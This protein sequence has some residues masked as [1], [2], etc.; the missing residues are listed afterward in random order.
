MIT[1]ELTDKII[2]SIKYNEIYYVDQND[3]LDDLS[4]TRWLELIRTGY[5]EIGITEDWDTSYAEDEIFNW[6]IKDFFPDGIEDEDYS[7]LRDIIW[8]NCSNDPMSQLLRHTKDQ[9]IIHVIGD[10]DDVELPPEVLDSEDYGEWDLYTFRTGILLGRTLDEML[11][12]FYDNG[13]VSSSEYYKY[14]SIYNEGFGYTQLC[15]AYKMKASDIPDIR[16]QFSNGDIVMLKWGDVGVINNSEGSGWMDSNTFAVDPVFTFDINQCYHDK[17]MGR[18]GYY[19]EVCWGDASEGY[20]KVLTKIATPLVTEDP[21][22]A[23][24]KS[25]AKYQ[26]IYN[27]WGCSVGDTDIRRHRNTKYI[28]EYPCGTHCDKCHMFWID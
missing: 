18:Y 5:L 1:K 20:L 25:E 28:N 21:L 9:D 26:A 10:L 24:R 13:G 4:P 8:E 19:D 7:S 11:A 23:T 17:A 2:E 12:M 14:Y 16:N 15:V 3:D 27:A 22:V 6:I